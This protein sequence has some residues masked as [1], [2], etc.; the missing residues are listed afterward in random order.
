MEPLP[1]ADFSYIGRPAETYEGRWAAIEAAVADRLGNKED[2]KISV[3]DIGS[4]SGYFSLCMARRF[5]G[6][7]V[8]GIEGSVGVGNGDLGIST[9]NPGR[10][11]ATTAV[12]KHLAWVDKLGLT[13][14][15]VAPEVWDLSS[16]EELAAAGLRA[17]VVLH[18]SVVHHIDNICHEEYRRRGLDLVEG[19]LHL[20]AALLRLGDLHV[21]ELPDKPWMEHL[22]NRF[23]SAEAIIEA[24]LVRTGEEWTRRMIY[25][26]TWYGTRELWLIT[27]CKAAEAPTIGASLRPFFKV[28]LPPDILKDDIDNTVEEEDN[29]EPDFSS[30]LL[31]GRWTNK[32]G[33]VI[34]VTGAAPEMLCLYTK[35]VAASPTG[36]SEKRCLRLVKGFWCLQTPAGNFLLQGATKDKLTWRDFGG[37][38]CTEWVRA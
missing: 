2:A 20:L 26:N 6:S 10:L 13:N 17:D 8:V 36:V 24:A 27:S 4:N 7:E 16:V 37:S 25:R 9:R 32:Y 23:G 19:S 38:F 34:D 33:F 35:A 30:C 31:T 3:L 18:L 11:A 22:H 29:E 14:C 21:L 15:A 12:Q 1:A 28:L 5:P